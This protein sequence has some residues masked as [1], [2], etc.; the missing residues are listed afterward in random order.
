MDNQILDN[1]NKKKFS[2]PEVLY[3]VFLRVLKIVLF[4][5]SLTFLFWLFLLKSYIMF[6][7]ILGVVLGSVA[8]ILTNSRKGS[9]KD[10]PEEEKVKEQEKKELVT[11][12]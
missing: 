8:E 6:T 5:L 1:L 10:R 12:E 4:C 2:S 11:S 3:L 7:L 9:L